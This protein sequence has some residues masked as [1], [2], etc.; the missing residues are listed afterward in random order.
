MYLNVIFPG[1]INNLVAQCRFQQ[2]RLS[3]YT[4]HKK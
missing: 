2:V 1:E 4:V 3:K